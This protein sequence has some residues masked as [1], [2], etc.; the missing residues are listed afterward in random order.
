MKVTVTTTS[1]DPWLEIS[2]Y[3]QQLPG[4]LYGGTAVFVGTMRDFNEDLSVSH[5][6]LEHYPGMTEKHLEKICQEAIK[7]WQLLDAMIIHRVGDIKPADPIVLVVAW[8]AHRS[9]AFEASRY[10]I[11]DLKHSAPFW[12]KENTQNGYRWVEK[13]TPS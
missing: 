11:E 6:T 4:G 2:Q 8:A 13:N 3:Q 9:E 10:M 5:M 12:K 7:R 1:F